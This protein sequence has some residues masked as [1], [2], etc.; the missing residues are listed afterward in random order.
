MPTRLKF[1]F[2][3]DDDVEDR[4]SQSFPME[5]YREQGG[6]RTLRRTTFLPERREPRA[7]AERYVRKVKI[8]EVTTND[9]TVSLQ[10]A[11]RSTF[12]IVQLLIAGGL[13][14]M[15]MY[16]LGDAISFGLKALLGLAIFVAGYMFIKSLRSDDGDNGKGR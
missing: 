10:G 15:A 7:T 13:A 6:N 12:D 8:E 9:S 4:V 1:R 5:E 16:Y 3:N 14:V 2:S 11:M